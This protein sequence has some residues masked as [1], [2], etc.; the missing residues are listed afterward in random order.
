[1]ELTS[2]DSTAPIGI[3]LIDPARPHEQLVVWP[4]A[5]TPS[6]VIGLG[7]YPA[8]TVLHFRA[9]Q[10][11]EENDSRE[12]ATVIGKVPG[13]DVLIVEMNVG[14]SVLTLGLSAT[15][16]DLEYSGDVRNLTEEGDGHAQGGHACY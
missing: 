16:W 1:L 15:P 7:F 12:A 10:G 11:E 8:G 2:A 3:E 4:D 5:Q 9:S 14:S 6:P 13:E